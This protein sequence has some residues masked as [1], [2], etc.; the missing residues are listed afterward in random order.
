MRGPTRS[1]PPRPPAAP[2]ETIVTSTCGH[3]CGGRCVVNAH[4]RDGRIVRI[5]TDPRKWTPEDVPLHACV[6]GFGQLERL[7]H[8]DRLTHPLRRVGPRGSGRF[9]RIGWGATLDAGAPHM[10]RLP[11]PHGPAAIRDCSRTGSLSMLHSRSTV[12]RLLYMFGG[13][14]ELWTNISAEAEVYAGH[15]TY[16]EK[17]DYKSA[18]REPTDYVNSR[19]IL[20]WGWSPADGTFGTGTLQYL[21]L[22][23]QRGVQFICVDPRRTRTSWELAEQHVFI[24]PSTDTAALVATAYVILSA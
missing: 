12:K 4:V 21:K 6:R 5:S 11:D 13:C 9:E 10:L 1:E 8:P 15:Q 19:L 7:N 23:K 2:G 3:N 24:R 22:A 16:R 17:A 14:T 18:G 20:M